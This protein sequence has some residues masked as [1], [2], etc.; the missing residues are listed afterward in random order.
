MIVVGIA[1][2]KR[3]AAVRSGADDSISLGVSISL[4][5]FGTRNIVSQ[6]EVLQWKYAGVE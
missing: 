5:Q 3:T 6:P 1:I 4:G 2:R